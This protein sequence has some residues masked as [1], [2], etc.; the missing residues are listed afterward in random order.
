MEIQLETLT[1]I[2]KRKRTT[3]GITINT[4]GLYITKDAAIRYKLCGNIHA[5]LF[6]HDAT[7][8]VFIGYK[9]INDVPHSLRPYIYDVQISED[10]HGN[11]SAYKVHC[12][13]IKRIY[14][15]GG[16]VSLEAEAITVSGKYALLLKTNQPND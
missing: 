2:K 7:S 5:V 8:L 11:V 10:K 1:P 6:E 9:D 14:A 4:S 13:E 15:K 16:A 12:S 3:S